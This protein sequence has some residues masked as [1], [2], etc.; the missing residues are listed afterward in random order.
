M[1]NALVPG[2]GGPMGAHATP[3][4]LWFRPLPWAILAATASFLIL[5]LRH[6]EIGAKLLRLLSLMKTRDS[7]HD[8]RLWEYELGDE[9]FV[10]GNPFDE[11]RRHLI[12]GA[13]EG[14]VL[15]NPAKS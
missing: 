7:G 4:G 12:R 2:L 14:D 11:C 15:P 9:G 1:H 10:V 6:V 5:F 3:R 13:P 8:V